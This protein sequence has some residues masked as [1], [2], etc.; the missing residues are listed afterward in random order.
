MHQEISSIREY[1]SVKWP[2]KVYTKPLPTNYEVPCMYFQPP[3]IT[4]EKDT[5]STFSKTYTLSIHIIHSDSEQAVTKADEIAD[6]IRVERFLIPLL[7]SNGSP[8]GDYIRIQGMEIKE[9]DEVTGNLTINWS[10]RYHYNRD[11]YYKMINL[12][13]EEVVK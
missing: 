10:S 6:S 13:L 9:L 11:L 2:V 8:S 4:D 1:C 3:V 5:A 12:Y 7:D